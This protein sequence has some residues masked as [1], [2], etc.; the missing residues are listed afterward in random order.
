MSLPLFLL[1]ISLVIFAS[2][3][4]YYLNITAYKRDLARRE[5]AISR[6][7]YELAI[8]KELGE[9]IGYSL[10]VQEITDIIVGSLHQFIEYTVVSYMLIG[11]EKIVFKSHLEQ[12]VTR[13][14]LDVVKKR[15]IGSLSALL[16]SDLQKVPI[17]EVLSGAI[18]IEDIDKNV[19]SYF[20]IPLVIGDKVEGVLTVA[21]TQAGLYKEEE[22]TILYKITQ[23]A[24]QAVTKLHN[25]VATEQ[26]KLNAMVE[27]MVE[28]VIMTDTDYRILVANPAVRTLLGL[29]DKSDLTIFNCIDKMN[30]AYD[31]QGKLEESIKLD[32]VL[33]TPDVVINGRVFQIFVSPVKNITPEIKQTLGGVVIFHDIT[34]EKEIERMRDDFTSM[35]VHELRSPLDNIKKMSEY[36]RS[37]EGARKRKAI[38]EYLK[39]IY[40]DSSSMLSMV[41]DLLDAAKLEAGKFEIR[42][43][44]GDI[45]S[46]IENRVRFFE[47]QAKDA[48]IKLTITIAKNVPEQIQIDSGAIAQ[49]LNNLLS[50]A[51][52]FSSSGGVIQLQALSHKANATIREEIKAENYTWFTDDEMEKL[53]VFP[54]SII[55]AV[56]DNGRGI[57]Q[58]NINELFNKFKQFQARATEGDKKGTGL[59]LYIVKG[60]VEAHGGAVRAASIEG[61]GSTFYCIIPL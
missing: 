15:M 7:M 39:L 27:S 20:N 35:M 29:D 43:E 19:N 38:K 48:G 13:E 41:N 47:T 59:G 49:V 31:F 4:T 56:T 32:K 16:D 26:R 2:I 8:L 25:V 24:S 11:P 37:E 61:K 5:G 17:E 10:D 45:R 52:K 60:I 54:D 18:L 51:I 22:M 6:K 42:K 53:N 34:H 46:V 58:N 14:F 30:G 12:S 55:L 23:Q 21:H 36:M 44:A 9:R 40:A 50:N 3:I 1:L 28:G 57:S 33:F